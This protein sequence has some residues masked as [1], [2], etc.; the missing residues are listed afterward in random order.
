MNIFCVLFVSYIVWIHRDGTA[1]TVA[2]VPVR[3]I[4]VLIVDDSGPCRSMIERSMSVIRNDEVECHVCCDQASD[5][6]KSV[7]MI[8]SMMNALTL[9]PS[10]Q[11]SDSIRISAVTKKTKRAVNVVSVHAVYDLIFMDYQMPHMDGPTAIRRI[12]ELGYRG[13]IIGLTGNILGSEIDLMYES[14]AD[15]VLSK[16]VQ[17][18]AIEA[19]ILEL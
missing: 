16:P 13:Q 8:K 14:G 9:G 4:N 1:V 2:K 6:Q 10:S 19:L 11:S 18:S 17:L 3:V 5:G 12:R 15:R 7:E